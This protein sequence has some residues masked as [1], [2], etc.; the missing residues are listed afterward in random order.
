[1]GQDG[2]SENTGVIMKKW[3]F[4]QNAWQPLEGGYSRKVKVRGELQLTPCNSDSRKQVMLSQG[5]GL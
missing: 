5:E 3:Y 4:I 1:M 2:V